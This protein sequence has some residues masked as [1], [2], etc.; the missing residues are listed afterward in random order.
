MATE[1]YDPINHS[2]GSQFATE[3]AEGSR[4][5]LRGA[6]TG[7]IIGALGAAVI[8]GLLFGLPTYG[9]ISAIGVA[10]PETIAAL[11]LP[12]VGAVTLGGAL[13][14]GL[15]GGTMGAGYGAIGGGILGAAK[16]MNRG[17]NVAEH[18]KA[19]YRAQAAYQEHKGDLRSYA[20]AAMA[21]AQTQND[22]N[23]LKAQELQLRAAELELAAKPQTRVSNEQTHKHQSS[24]FMA[25]DVPDTKVDAATIANSQAVAAQHDGRV[26]A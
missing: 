26:N 1:Q 19:A 22:A 20:E 14:G 15:F 2:G 6:L 16:G 21:N 25:A 3:I 9:V 13:L 18:E 11:T 4:S 7:V 12:V 24:E 5:G 17:H 23:M 8:G 10:F